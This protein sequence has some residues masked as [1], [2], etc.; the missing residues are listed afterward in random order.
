MNIRLASEA[1]GLPARTI[2]YYES[3]A[4]LTPARDGNGYRDFSAADVH[5]LQFLARAR[6]LGFTI[7]DC[8][9]LLNLW[10]DRQRASA[11]VKRIAAEHV[12]AIEA[13]IDELRRMH[14]TLTHLMK[15]CQGNDRPDCPIIDG[16]ASGH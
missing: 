14:D 8:R 16:L 1:S 7:E 13:K 9:A 15:H 10:E 5:K 3:I 6:S 2:R 11:D 12:K 4:L